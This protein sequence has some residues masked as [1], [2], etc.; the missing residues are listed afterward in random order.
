[1]P[2]STLDLTLDGPALTARLVDFP[3]VSGDEKELADAIETALR[4]L[5]HLAVDRYGNNVVARTQLG[6]TERVVLAGHIDTVPIADNVPSRL[7]ENGVLWGCGTSDM[8]SGVAVQLRIAATVPEPNRD[9]TFVFYDN[10]EVAAHL[11]GLGHV[12]DA[13]PDWLEGDFAVLL[14]PSDGQVEG[15]CQG[16]LRV[17]LRTE[18]ERAHSA[19]SWMGSN[20]I[21]AAAPILGRLAAYEPRRPV[22]DGLEYHEGLNAVRIEAG[23]ANNVIPDACTVVV[24]Y[25]YAPDRSAEEALAHVH[26]VFADCGVVEFTVDDHSGAAMPGLSHPAAEAFMAAVGGTAQ[27]KFGWT[28]VS[29]FGALGVPAVNYGPGDALLAH[30]RN[31]HVAVDRITHCEERLRSWLTG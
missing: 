26:E 11:N 23:V 3:S 22:I 9:L 6:R 21:H 29:R 28:D 13:H 31:E 15:G 5:P 20:A 25:R 14:E 1:M 16:T 27:P 2:E 18:G 17:F 24:N 10:E 4:A 8:K 19:R 12:A 30:K 7:D